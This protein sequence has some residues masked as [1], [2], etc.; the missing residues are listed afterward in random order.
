MSLQDAIVETRGFFVKTGE[1]RSGC[2]TSRL[3]SRGFRVDVGTCGE[4]NGKTKEYNG[5][6]TH[7]IGRARSRFHVFDPRTVRGVRFFR[8]HEEKE[9]KFGR[10]LSSPEN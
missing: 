9:A 10:F 1:M 7:E 6:K 3:D 5:M 2:V 4:K 8:R